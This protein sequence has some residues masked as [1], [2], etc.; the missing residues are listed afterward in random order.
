MGGYARLISKERKLANNSTI[1]FIFN[2]WS[3]NMVQAHFWGKK[4]FV[5]GLLV[6]DIANHSYVPNT[7]LTQALNPLHKHLQVTNLVELYLFVRKPLSITQQLLDIRL[8]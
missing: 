1:S 3:H 6:R 4:H 2:F 8:K 5:L 7:P